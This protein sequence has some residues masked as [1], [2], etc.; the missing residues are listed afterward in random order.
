MSERTTTC[1]ISEPNSKGMTSTTT[2]ESQ[3]MATT[4]TLIPPRDQVIY[5]DQL[6][7]AE[8]GEVQAVAASQIRLLTSYY[9]AVLAQAT[10]SF[11]WALIAAGIG[12]VFFL[13]A[14]VLLITIQSQSIATIS[15]IGGAIVEVIAGINFFLY[16]KTTT[17]LAHFHE[18]LDRTQRFLLANS[19]CETLGDETQQKSRSELVRIIATF[20]LDSPKMPGEK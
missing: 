2:S 12:L 6:S 1:T 13:G 19:I 11:Q 4:T 14:V 18:R 7:E 9:S 3:E 8:P 10:K 16:G 20:G 17:Q 5:L 15:V